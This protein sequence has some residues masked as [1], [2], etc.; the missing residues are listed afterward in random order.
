M[1]ANSNSSADCFVSGLSAV[2]A[3]NYHLA[4]DEFTKAIQLDSQHGEAYFNRGLAHYF[5]NKQNES[6]S[7]YSKAIELDSQDS[8]AYNGRGLLYYQQKKTP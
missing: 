6:L 3:N 5:L 1:I 7:D 8:D 4:V 2:D